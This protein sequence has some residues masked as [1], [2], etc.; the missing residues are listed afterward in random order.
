MN[1]QVSF[2][3]TCKTWSRPFCCCWSIATFEF[4]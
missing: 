4:L 2:N 3:L 1:H